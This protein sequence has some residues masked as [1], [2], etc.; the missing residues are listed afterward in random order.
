MKKII[1][2][3]LAICLLGLGV[4]VAGPMDGHLER[5]ADSGRGDFAGGQFAKSFLKKVDGRETCYVH[6]FSET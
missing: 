4:S 6:C 1:H 2:S 5:A 3:L